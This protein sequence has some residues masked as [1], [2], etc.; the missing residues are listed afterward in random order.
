MDDQDFVLDWDP[1]C[2]RVRIMNM[3]IGEQI[4]I[5][6]YLIESESSY[7]L[8]W[9]ALCRSLMGASPGTESSMRI[10]SCQ[11]VNRRVG[12]VP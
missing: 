11:E 1:R 5:D 2:D 4:E 8:F 6:P 3:P 7:S 12:S 10:R 9:A